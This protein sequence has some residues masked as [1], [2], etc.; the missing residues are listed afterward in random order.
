[1]ASV[2]GLLHRPVSGY[3]HLVGE[4]GPMLA[5]LIVT[6]LSAGKAGIHELLRRMFRWRVNLGWHLIAWFSPVVLF[7]MAAV[8]VRVVS[9][10]WPDLSQFGRTEEYPQLPLLV[11]WAAGLFFYGW[12]EE[13]GWRGFA[14]PRLQKD[15]NALA[16]TF[17]LSL[18]WALWHLP[19]FWFIDGFMKMGTG[20]VLGWYFSIL[21]GAILLTWLYNGTQGS[22]WIVAV[23]HTMVDIVFNIPI[24]GNFA[25]ILG[26]LMTLWGIA[27]LFLNRPARL[28]RSLKQV[29]E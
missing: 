27:M 14:L 10:I 13:T 17:I 19:L 8:I 25:A 12:G 20:G 3:L 29:P 24:S 1:M 6:G 26:M 28:S 11:Y 21:L 4:L 2:Q 9:G 5:A 16:A 15:H 18:F 7:G 22:I 23:F